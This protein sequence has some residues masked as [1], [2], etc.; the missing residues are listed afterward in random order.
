[1]FA[2][3]LLFTLMAGILILDKIF[4]PK[5]ARRAWRALFFVYGLA[6]L[7]ALFQDGL[8]ILAHR[9]G[10]G[11]GVDLVIYL[12]IVVLVRELFLSRARKVVQDA[13]F[14]KLVREMALDKAI[15]HRCEPGN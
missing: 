9:L 14:T 15:C 6:A 10:I 12:V 8:S 13:S 3:F 11:R 4:M 7:A 2:V 1:M 5:A